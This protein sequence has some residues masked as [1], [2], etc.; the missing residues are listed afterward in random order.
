MNT[1]SMSFSAVPSKTME[2]SDTQQ[3]KETLRLGGEGVLA[4][5]FAAEAPRLKRMLMF[6]M[7]PQLRRRLD[8]DDLLQ[9]T[10]LRIRH[11][12]M[13]NVDSRITHFY[14]WLYQQ[15]SQTLIDLYRQH[16]R[17][18]KRDVN[19]EVTFDDSLRNPSSEMLN[20]FLVASLTSPSDAASRRE[21]L[22][23]I[24]EGLASMEKIDQEII[25]MCHF[26][27]LSM[28]E[29]AELH[30]LKT[31]AARHRYHQSLR[32]L[33]RQIQADVAIPP[34]GSAVGP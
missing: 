21:N 4:E 20:E 6:R 16:C 5:L 31:S 29:I 32:R 25:T 2:R 9:E 26:E 10:W 27:G 23:K 1:N 8:A 28:F 3:Q 15:A 14:V 34:A 22:E 17:S 24:H 12:Y 11:R 19:C 13:S 18:Q 7:A 30:D 33:R